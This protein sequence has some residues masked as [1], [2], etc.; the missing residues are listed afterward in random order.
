MTCAS[1]EIAKIVTAFSVARAWRKAPDT[2]MT[3]IILT[4]TV[5]DIYRIIMADIIDPVA[6]LRRAIK[7]S[8]GD[9]C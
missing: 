3:T 8:Y 7:S 5:P 9:Q 6:Q 4:E 1:V 2:S